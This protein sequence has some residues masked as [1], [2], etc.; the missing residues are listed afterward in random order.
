MELSKKLG[1]PLVAT[2]DAHY[3]NHEDSDL[4]DTLLCIGT[5]TTKAKEKRMRFATDQFFVKAPDE[6]RAVFPDHPEYLERTLEIA[7]KVDLFPSTRKPVTPSF[8]VENGHA[9]DSY[10]VQVARE[11]FEMRVQKCRPFWAAGALKYPEEKYRE[12][13][14]FEINTILSMGFPGYFLLVWDFIA[15]AR[16]MGVPVGPGRGSAAGSIVAWAMK[17]TDIDPMQYDLLFERFL[18]PGVVHARCGH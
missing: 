2:N 10:F 11:Y 14:E 6:M 4:H 9:L 17:I 15:K 13:L 7:A 18:N 16:E 1:I 3:L 12:R 5:K 8:P